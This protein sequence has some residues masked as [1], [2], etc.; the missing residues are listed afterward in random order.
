MARPP[1]EGESCSQAE[2]MFPFCAWQRCWQPFHGLPALWMQQQMGQVCQGLPS[3]LAAC[4]ARPSL[5]PGHA[6]LAAIPKE[7]SSAV[8]L[9]KAASSSGGQRVQ[10]QNSRV[11]GHPLWLGFPPGA[12]TWASCGRSREDFW[13]Q[14][15]KVLWRCRCNPAVME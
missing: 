5:L 10:R 8:T 7:T 9:L 2:V 4:S 11:W 12:Q 13:V 14:L 15:H 6:R 3:R 1:S